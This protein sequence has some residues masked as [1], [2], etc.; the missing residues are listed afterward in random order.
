MAIRNLNPYLNFNGD[1]EKAIGAY[2]RILGAKIDGE[3]NRY[4]DMPPGSHPMTDEQK[5]RV[6]HAKLNIGPG[7][8]MV[9]DGPPGQPVPVGGNTHVCLDFDD[10]SEA[11]A[12]FDALAQG[13][14]VHMAFKDQ[15]WGAKFGML[16]DAFGIQWMFNCEN[17]KA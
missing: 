1:A 4:G 16:V 17:K 10:A 3:V 14:K 11:A 9:S 2:Q 15:F 5:K 8:I 7:T 6:M 13:G 12:K